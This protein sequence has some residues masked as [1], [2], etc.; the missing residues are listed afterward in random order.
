[1]PYIKKSEIPFVRVRR[2]LLGYELDAVRLSKVLGCSYGTA[3]ARLENPATLT[4][5]ELDLINTRGHVPVDEL[6]AAMIR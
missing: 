1:M 6:R 2:L 5:A 4:L 3:K